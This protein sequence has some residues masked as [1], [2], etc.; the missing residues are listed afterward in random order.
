MKIDCF[1]K[2]NDAG[3]NNVGIYRCG[4]GDASIRIDIA[5]KCN[6]YTMS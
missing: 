4:A 2:D 6:S 5:C 1:D 3:N